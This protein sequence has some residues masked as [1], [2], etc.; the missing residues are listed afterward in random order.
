MKKLTLLALALPLVATLS[1]NEANAEGLGVHG[2]L[3]LPMGDFSDFAGLGF[4]GGVS[5]TRELNEN[6]TYAAKVSYLTFGGKDVDAFGGS[7]EYSYSMIPVV[8]KTNY[9]FG[10]SESMRFYG[11]LSAGYYFVSVDVGSASSSSGEIG[12]APGVGME[13]GNL[14]FNAEYHLIDGSNL[15]YLGINVGY[16]F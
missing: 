12:F 6:M 3:G 5:W 16:N 9:Y 7:T 15:T 13:M 11:S 14:D 1:I 4:G 2:T 10:G 8:A